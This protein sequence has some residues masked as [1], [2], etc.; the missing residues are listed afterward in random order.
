MYIIYCF[1]DRGSSSLYRCQIFTESACDSISVMFTITHC[2][3][4]DADLDL[5]QRVQFTLILTSVE[6]GA[7]PFKEP[8]NCVYTFLF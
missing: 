8:I 1:L 7:H 6:R 3:K 4:H 2:C 5:D